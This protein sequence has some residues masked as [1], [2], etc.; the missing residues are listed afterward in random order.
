MTGHQAAS[1]QVSVNSALT[2]VYCS[3]MHT[4][5]VLQTCEYFNI[6]LCMPC[7]WAP[8][9]TGTTLADASNQWCPSGNPMSI[10]IIGTHWKTTGSIL[11][12]KNYFSSGI[13]LHT[14]VLVPGTLDYHCIATELPLAQ[15][16]GWN[17]RHRSYPNVKINE[18]QTIQNKLMKLLLRL[19]PKTQ[20]DE[21]HK[22][23]NIS[24]VSDICKSNILYLVYELLTR[25]CPESFKRETQDMQRKHQL[26]IS[27]S[28]ICLGN[29]DPRSYNASL[30][31]KTSNIMA[32]YHFPRNGIESILRVL[33]KIEWTRIHIP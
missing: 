24:K 30:W 29:T 18:E 20:T 7:I 11:A 16:R 5:S 22:N 4:S 8:L 10:C 14:G 27:S 12:T 28:R 25:R 17:W 1:G 26:Q 21:L 31:N 19:D 23:M 32:Q 15:G 13:P 2:W 9:Y 3:A 33:W 6:T